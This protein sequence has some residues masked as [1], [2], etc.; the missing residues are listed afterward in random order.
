MCEN[1]QFMADALFKEG[2]IETAK[3]NVLVEA[4][5]CSSTGTE[6]KCMYRE[7]EDCK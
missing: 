7:C 3:L 1:T 4:M 2:V 6:K 5:V